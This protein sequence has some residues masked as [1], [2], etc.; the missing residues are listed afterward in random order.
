MS[1]PYGTETASKASIFSLLNPAPLQD[2]VQRSTMP[3]LI[4][5][6]TDDE[7]I[8]I[9]TS[10]TRSRYERRGRT[11][12]RGIRKSYRRSPYPHDSAV[13]R[14]SSTGRE[15]RPYRL[16]KHARVSLD[17]YL[18]EA[19]LDKEARKCR[20]EWLKDEANRVETPRPPSHSQSEVRALARWLADYS[21]NTLS[22]ERPGKNCFCCCYHR[23]ISLTFLPRFWQRDLAG[24][25]TS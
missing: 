11:T 8:S 14:R 21:Y 9:S 5:E 4:S 25:A 15:G 19:D 3:A 7:Q 12:T 20:A 24:G 23:R 2:F 18:N 13:F 10:S 6:I 1:L 22:D 16:T 17:A